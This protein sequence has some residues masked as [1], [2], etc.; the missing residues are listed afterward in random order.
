MERRSSPL[1]LNPVQAA[2]LLGI[3]RTQVFRLIRSGELDSIKVGALRKI[4]LDAAH[5]FVDR[6][7][8][9]AREAVA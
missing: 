7:L 2:A 5:D 8:T 1:L 4:P 9:E 6:K 3:S